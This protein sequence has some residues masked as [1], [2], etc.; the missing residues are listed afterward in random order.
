M[1]GSSACRFSVLCL[2]V[3]IACCSAVL[4]MWLLEALSPCL[5]RPFLLAFRLH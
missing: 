1:A 3:G 4:V 5:L 2:A